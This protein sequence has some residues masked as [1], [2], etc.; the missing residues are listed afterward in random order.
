MRDQGLW[1][2]QRIRVVKQLLACQVS[3]VNEFT[4]SDLMFPISHLR[5]PDANLHVVVLIVCL[6]EERAGEGREERLVG[7]SVVG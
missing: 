5:E 7:Q 3:R 6:F 2:H 1:D 4:L